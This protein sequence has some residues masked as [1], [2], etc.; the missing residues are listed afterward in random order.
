MPNPGNAGFL[1]KDNHVKAK[2]NGH[3]LFAKTSLSLEKLPA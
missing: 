2:Y 1:F 3:S